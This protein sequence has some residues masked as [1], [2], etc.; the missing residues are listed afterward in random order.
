MELSVSQRRAIARK[1]AR[2]ATD[3][4]ELM[5][6]AAESLR[7]QAERQASC[8]SLFHISSSASRYL[9][10]AIVATGEL[11]KK[12]SL[13][14][15]M[16]REMMM[17]FLPRLLLGVSWHDADVASKQLVEMAESLRIQSRNAMEG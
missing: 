3:A 8:P 11:R 2:L 7:L 17:E 10:E 5:D 13:D 14:V 16:M 9:A 4:A 6:A 15:T 1:A 12:T